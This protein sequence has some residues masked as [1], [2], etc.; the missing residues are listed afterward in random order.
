VANKDR[1]PSYID[2]Y[3]ESAW[4]KRQSKEYL[5]QFINQDEHRPVLPPFTETLLGSPVGHVIYNFSEPVPI[6]DKLEPVFEE[7]APKLT[8]LMDL[9]D[10]YPVVAV[11][12]HPSTNAYNSDVVDIMDHDQKGCQWSMVLPPSSSVANIV[13]AV[14]EH[15]KESHGRRVKIRNSEDE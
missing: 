3:K 12:V 10:Q 11:Q 14:L 7:P 9:L 4:E 15:E 5:K 8:K 2:P 13:K 6:L 1:S